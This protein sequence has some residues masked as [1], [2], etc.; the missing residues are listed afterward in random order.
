MATVAPSSL[1]ATPHDVEHPPDI[2]DLTAEGVLAY[3]VD[4]GLF[5]PETYETWKALEQR[6]D[7]EIESAHGGMS[8][9]RQAHAAVGAFDLD[10]VALL[11]GLPGLVGLGGEQPG[12]DRV[13]EHALG[14]QVLD[15]GRM[16]DVV[17]GG[18]QAGGSYRRHLRPRTRPRRG[19]PRT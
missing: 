12:V 10:V 6:Y 7:I 11:E 16:L 9:A 18:P 17:R 15:V 13:G 8:L 19:S 2:E 14:G 4:T 3:A 5:S 1:R